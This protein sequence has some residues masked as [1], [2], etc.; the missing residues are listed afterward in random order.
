MCVDSDLFGQVI[1]TNDDVELWLRTVPRFTDDTRIN[2]VQDYIKNYDVVN[3]II[4]A[5]HDGSFYRLNDSPY[6]DNQNLSYNLKHLLKSKF[7]RSAHIPFSLFKK[8]DLSLI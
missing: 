3:K 7:V 8:R 1:V 4:R 5:K 6:I 2:H